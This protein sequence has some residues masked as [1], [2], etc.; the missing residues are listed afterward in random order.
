MVSFTPVSHAHSGA[1]AIIASGPSFSGVP[2]QHL[3]ERVPIIAV[4]GA[5]GGLKRA[6]YWITVDANKWCRKDYM[7]SR[8]H[9][10]AY[11]YAA[12]PYDYG[13]PTA[14]RLWHRAEAET[15]IH[16]LE[17]VEG[18]GLS[19][20]PRKLHTGN[21]AYAAL[22]LAYHMGFTKIGLFGVDG[23]QQNYGIGYGAPRG[24][25]EKIH[26]LFGEAIPQLQARG[27]EVRNAGQLRTWPQEHWR[28]VIRWLNAA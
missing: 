24:D 3:K 28:D 7:G 6:T 20:D 16:W 23:N 14:Q 5:I 4:K 11:Y 1:V 22:G 19:E 15:D 12:V 21:S 18:P 10:T 27:V 9:E 25:L 26:G 17:R 2:F 8:R 13:M